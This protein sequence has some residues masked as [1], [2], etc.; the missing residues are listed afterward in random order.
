MSLNVWILAAVLAAAVLLVAGVGW[1]LAVQRWYRLRAEPGELLRVTTSDGWVLGVHH[2]RARVRRFSEPV[3]LAHGLAANHRNLDF[4]PPYSLAHVLNDAGFDTYSVDW[5]GTMHSEPPPRGFLAGH[6]SVDD[7]IEKDAPALIKLALEH[8]GAAQAFWIGHSLGGLIGYAAAGGASAEK[9]K[10]LVTIGS[11]VFF[12]FPKLI[13]YAVQLGALTAWPFRFRNRLASIALAPF[14]GHVTLPLSDTIV[15][16]KHIHPHVQRKA[17]ANVM[18]SISRRVL[19]Q[20]NDWIRHDVFR[21]ADGKTDYR[22]RIA[23]LRV[24]LLIT[25]G[26]ADKL[27]TTDGVKKAFELAGTQDKTLVVFGPENGDKQDYGHGDLVFG[28]NAPA[29]VFPVIVRW[30][31]ARAAPR[32]GAAA[33]KSTHADVGGSSVV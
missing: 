32:H 20:F 17:Y 33:S 6:Y 3:I 30:L 25:A 12:R 15:N 4:E 8:S 2:R 10:G 26:S 21:S 27:A 1:L 24:P 11:P 13:Q 28:A 19:M 16:P 18:S 14:I 22:Q 31:Q 9:F 23:S 5:R 7:H 29:E